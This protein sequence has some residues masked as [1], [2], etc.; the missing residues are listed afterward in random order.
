MEAFSLGNADL[1]LLFIIIIGGI[2]LFFQILSKLIK[3]N[4]GADSLAAIALVTSVI[5]HEY[6]AGTLII[7]MLASGQTLETYARRKAASALLALAARMPSIAHRQTNNH[8]E[9]IPLSTIQIKDQVVIYPHETCPVDGL[10]IHGQ[11]TMD[12]SYLTGEPYLIAKTPGTYVLSGAIN[13]DFALTVQTTSLPSDSRYAAIV[14]VLEEAE[15]KRPT[16]RR[17]G[18]QIGAIFAPLA[19]FFALLAWYMTGDALRFLAVIVIATPCPLLIAIPIVLISAVSKAAKQ[20]IIIK[21]PAI[22]EQL[23]LCKTAIFDKTGTLTYGKPSLTEIVA[24]D[25]YQKEK[26]LQYV[27]SLEQYSKHPLAYAVLNEA[28]KQGINLLQ[29]TNLSEKPGCGLQG[30]INKHAIS[31]ISRK[32]LLEMSP[33]DKAL[34]PPVLPGLECIILIDQRYAAA[35]HFRDA[36]RSDSKPFI[37]HLGPS[38]QF[39]KVMLVSGDRQSEVEY[40][41]TLLNLTEIYASQSPEQKLTIVRQERKKAPTV[42]M[43]D[44]INDAPALT[45]ATVGIA[46]GQH[47][48]ITSE[49]AGAIIMESTLSK[50]DELIHL[51]ISTRRI[52]AQSAIG[53]MILSIIGMVFAA[54]GFIPPVAGALL[55][56]FI[57][58]IAIIN[59]LRLAIGQKIKIDLPK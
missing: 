59:A 56:E 55:Q 8:I 39:K 52:A 50:V 42:F 1:P 7:L 31:I 14:K 26:I 32:K 17:L 23:P 6:L 38:H 11:G 36:P 5:L 25:D 2:P 28:K 4:L 9:D 27:A 21:D 29:V 51:S 18:D 20:A 35:L 37:S 43:G 47:S 16:L 58:I 54:A 12:E 40:L 30:T 46:F 49:A 53:G 41:A 57:D 44:G 22:L 33:A 24:V 48:A 19:L 45:A 3:G 34:L 13:R 10:V 15:Q